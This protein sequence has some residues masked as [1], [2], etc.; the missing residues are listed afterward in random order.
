MFHHLKNI[1]QQVTLPTVSA[2]QVMVTSSNGNIFHVTG[3]LW[4]ESTGHRWIPLTKAGDA[5]L[6]CFLWSAP[7]EQTVQQAIE[8]LVIWGAIELIMTSLQCGVL[9][10]WHP[11]TVCFMF[12]KV[13]PYDAY[14]RQQI[15]PYLVPI[16]AQ[17]NKLCH[18]FHI[19]LIVTGTLRN[20]LQLVTFE[21]KYNIFH[22]RKSIWKG[23][24]QNGSHFI[25]AT[26]FLFYFYF[27]Y[28]YTGYTNQF[29][30]FYL[31]ALC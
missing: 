13:R 20:R 7:P 6:W 24:L 17:G 14:I 15:K 27:K 19:R 31:G 4:G 30:L 18:L 1:T 11:Q 3:P 12:N 10:D 21:S 2:A 5:E 29:K 25:C 26:F 16:M 8:T 28:I 9:L 22:S 23:R